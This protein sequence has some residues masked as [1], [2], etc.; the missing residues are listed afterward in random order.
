M[1]SPLF[2]LSLRFAATRRTVYCTSTAVVN[3][4]FAAWVDTDEDGL[5]AQRGRHG[6]RQ[7]DR[8]AVVGERQRTRASHAA[9]T[10][11]SQQAASG[12]V[13]RCAQRRSDPAPEREGA[14]CGTVRGR[15]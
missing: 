10:V 3:N 7:S 13:M 8:P 11:R 2:A 5:R 14:M 4:F 15:R 1:L 9:F 6:G 12:C